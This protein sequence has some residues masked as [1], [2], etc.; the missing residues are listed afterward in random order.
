MIQA[1]ELR[2]GNWVIY[3]G[4]AYQI[5]TISPE[6]PILDADFGVGVV[7]YNNIHGIEL[8]PEILEKCGFDIDLSNNKICLLDLVSRCHYE[9]GNISLHF[10]TSFIKQE[11]NIYY[12]H[13][14]QNLYFSLTNN[15]LT[16]D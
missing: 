8:T 1:N 3:N 2:V 9:N 15:E 7:D 11:T 5:D 14:L 16:W 4:K 6:L 10:Y 12:L 13:Q